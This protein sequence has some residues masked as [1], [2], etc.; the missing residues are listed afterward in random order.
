MG[1]IGG[2]DYGII[3][4]SIAPVAIFKAK[5][6]SMNYVNSKLGIQMGYDLKKNENPINFYGKMAWHHEFNAKPTTII[7]DSISPFT[8]D[9]KIISSDKNWFSYGIGISAQFKKQHSIHVDLEK[10]TGADVDQKWGITGGY[11]FTF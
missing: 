11:R 3:N 8:T 9:T 2:T 6:D 5:T 10:T 1:K 7:Y 4:Q